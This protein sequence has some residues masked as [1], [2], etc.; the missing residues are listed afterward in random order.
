MATKGSYKDISNDSITARNITSFGLSVSQAAIN[1]RILNLPYLLNMA[2]NIYMAKDKVSTAT[3]EVSL[4]EGGRLV[5]P[6]KVRKYLNIAV[7]QKLF[8]KVEGNIIKL[9]TPEEA[10]KSLQNIVMSAVP[11]NYSLVDELIKERRAENE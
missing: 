8:M 9:Y 3:Y 7:G 4:L 6:S 1:G 5:I 11:S 2:Y 10:I